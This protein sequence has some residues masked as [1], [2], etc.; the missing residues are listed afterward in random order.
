MSVT[1]SQ[2]QEI[3]NL[4]I[5]RANRAILALDEKYAEEISEKAKV[6]LDE[7][8]PYASS[9][10]ILAERGKEIAK[11]IR[12]YRSD[13]ATL[14]NEVNTHL[15][16]VK[17]QYGN[18]ERSMLSVYMDTSFESK[19]GSDDLISLRG[20]MTEAARNQA[21]KEIPAHV[22]EVKAIREIVQNIDES[23]TLATT[24]T[25][26]KKLIQLVNRAFNIEESAFMQ[27][28]LQE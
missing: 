13:V 25:E 6:I 8:L 14:V 1:N 28:L 4:V 5:T 16:K 10:E 20:K 19:H 18:G 27:S 22:A 7:W 17:E 21:K 2:R 15:P 3:R 23:I 12:Q 24:T 26:I 11:H 9:A